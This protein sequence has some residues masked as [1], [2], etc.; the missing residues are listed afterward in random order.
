MGFRMLTMD[1]F[2]VWRTNGIV[3]AIETPERQ[4]YAA[5]KSAFE[6]T[7]GLIRRGA[8]RCRPGADKATGQR[9]AGEVSRQSRGGSGAANCRFGEAAG[10]EAKS[11]ELLRNHHLAFI[12]YRWKEWGGIEE[13]R[14]WAQEVLKVGKHVPLFLAGFVTAGS[15]QTVRQ[16]LSETADATQV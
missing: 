1:I 10:W 6:A 11:S 13:P 7:T 8:N 4:R 16:L 2:I 3:G 5:L 9:R 15:S 14:N 12:L